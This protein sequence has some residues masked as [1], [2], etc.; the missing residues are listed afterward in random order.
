MSAVLLPVTAF[1]L[2]RVFSCVEMACPCGCRR[3][4]GKGVEKCTK[5]L[6]GTGC[7]IAPPATE[8]EGAM[9]H[10]HHRKFAQKIGGQTLA[11]SVR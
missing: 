2:W 10:P 4:A 8:I 7:F 1:V 9:K 11:K 5:K 6:D 3:L